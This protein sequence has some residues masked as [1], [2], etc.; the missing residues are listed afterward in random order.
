MANKVV[1]KK[2]P[3]V[4]RIPF[5]I[6]SF[7]EGAAV[8]IVE[9]LGAKIIAPFY[10]SSLYVW[11]S[12]LG[13][14]LGA[15]AFG[16]YF[17]GFV[18]KKYNNAMALG[19]ILCIS[20]I[21]TILMPYFAPIIMDA[22]SSLGLKVGSALSVFSFLFI[23]VSG[24]GMVSPI[25]TQ[26]INT[27]QVHAG[28]SAGKVYAI[29]T[30]GGILATFIAGFYLIPELGIKITAISIGSLLMVL[31]II[32]FYFNKKIPY[33]VSVF[34]IFLI[35]LTVKGHKKKI[36]EETIIR[37]QSS[38]ILGE[39]TVVDRLAAIDKGDKLYTRHLLLNWIDQTYTQA[40]NPPLS[41][42][43]Y[44]HRLSAI[45]GVKPKDSKALLL[46]MGGGSITYNLIN[47]GFDVDVV[48]LDERIPKIAKRWFNFKP[49]Q[50]NVIIDDARHY[51][52]YTNQKYDVIVLDMLNGEEQPAHIF[53]IEGLQN[54]KQALNPNG[55][56]IVNFQGLFDK[57]NP[58]A[59]LAVRSVYK[60]FL[61]AGYNMKI[62]KQKDMGNPELSDDVLMYASP[63]KLSVYSTLK[64]NIRYNE[65][66][67]FKQFQF[68]IKDFDTISKISTNDAVV[69]TDDKMNLNIINDKTVASWRTKK[70]DA[71]IKQIL[72]KELPLFE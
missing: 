2:N 17:G 6:I 27:E 35:S 21:F 44:T 3:D 26:I 12:V 28:Y 30:L 14:T 29:S 7:I 23:P 64:N 39:W 32:V 9:L 20:S 57:D 70:I 65:L 45:A 60:T 47:L 36:D 63:G 8:M 72:E 24:M 51:I 43:Y 56:V 59:S 62:C 66:Y 18:S 50:A 46:G 15:L 38:G 22:V 5:L 31:S 4:K 55:L 42:W 34:L 41:L 13:V 52:R 19:L 10:G 61:G 11:A 54:L 71:V 67:P 49:D 1:K 16:Y 40:S 48:E 33:A 53:T 37:Y 69:F 25:I 68:N 58:E